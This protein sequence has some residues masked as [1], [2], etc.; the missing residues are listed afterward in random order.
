MPHLR[1]SARHRRGNNVR[2]ALSAAAGASGL[3]LLGLAVFGQ[4]D[5]YLRQAREQWDGLIDSLPPD[6]APDQAPAQKSAAMAARMAQLQQQVF[7]LRDELVAKRDDAE[8]A[9]QALAAAQVQRQAAETPLVT[10]SEAGQAPADVVPERYEAM[11]PAAAERHEPAAAERHEPAA[12]ERHE[13]AAA[14]RHDSF[15][16]PSAPKPPPRQEAENAQSVLARLRQ[17]APPA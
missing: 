6:Q 7:E 14:E 1:G 17:M 5:V 12:V 11:A 8:R 13:P 9:R 4:P 10:P 2:F 15:K 3:L 16:P